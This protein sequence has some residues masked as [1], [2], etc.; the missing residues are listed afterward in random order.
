MAEEGLTRAG[1]GRGG[2]AALAIMVVGVVAMM[3]IP[4]PT[5]LLDVLITINLALAVAVLLGAVYSARTLELSTFP[6]VLV[7][8]T[9]YQLSLNFSTA[10]LI[11]FQADAG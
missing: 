3:I 7:L 2:A 5:P 6:T 9:L 10:R 8:T 1:L 11:L 4:L